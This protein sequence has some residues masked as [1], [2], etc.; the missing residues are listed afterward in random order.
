MNTFNKEV[1]RNCL[2]VALHIYKRFDRLSTTLHWFIASKTRESCWS[3][4]YYFVNILL[5]HR[6]VSVCQVLRK[7]VAPHSPTSEPHTITHPGHTRINIMGR[8]GSQMVNANGHHPKYLLSLSPGKFALIHDM[9]ITI[10]PNKN[11]PPTSGHL[12]EHFQLPNP[13][14]WLVTVRRNGHGQQ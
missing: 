2:N 8:G 5:E 3:N 1:S 13:D 4:L 10:S 11:I 14:F 7:L 6:F 9:Y 12:R